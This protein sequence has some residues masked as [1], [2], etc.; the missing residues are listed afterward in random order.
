MRRVRNEGSFLD[1]QSVQDL[2]VGYDCRIVEVPES[3]V[4]EHF[5]YGTW[6][7]GSPSVRALQIAWPDRY[8]RFPWERGVEPRISAIQPVF[9]KEPLWTDFGSAGRDA[10]RKLVTALKGGLRTAVATGK[11]ETVRTC[12][13]GSRTVRFRIDF[14][15]PLD[16]T[17]TLFDDPDGR[18]RI[19]S[20]DEP[21]E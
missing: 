17:A 21:A 7:Y 8:G 13:D 2:L 16:V 19:E 20:L 14:E 5:G 11:Y 1:G 4:V 15:G 10:G 9:G 3:A 18:V 12:I 6:F